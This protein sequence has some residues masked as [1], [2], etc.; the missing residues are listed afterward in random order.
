MASSGKMKGSQDATRG[1]GLVQ[2]IEVNP[3]D[4]CVYQLLALPDAVFDPNVCLP[5]RIV[6]M[7]FQVCQKRGGQR[8]PAERGDLLDLGHVN[9]R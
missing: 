8:G 9:H 3:R 5:F 6:A 7:P 4:P 2:D 1:G